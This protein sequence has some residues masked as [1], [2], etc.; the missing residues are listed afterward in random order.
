[1]QVEKIYFDMDG[2]LA[3]FDRGITELGKIAKV[4]QSEATLATDDVLWNAV[5]CVDNFYNKLE[6]IAGAVE[7]FKKIY[8][9]YGD[10]CEILSA[11]PKPHRNI[12][13]AREDKIKWVRRLLSDQVVINLVYR[14]EKQNFVKGKGCILID[15]YQINIDEWTAAGGTGILFESAD[16]VLDRLMELET[17]FMSNNRQV[18][19]YKRNFTGQRVEEAMTLGEIVEETGLYEMEYIVDQYN[20][21]MP[22]YDWMSFR[23]SFDFR[24]LRYFYEDKKEESK[25]G[26]IN[27]SY[28]L[29]FL[30][31]ALALEKTGGLN[32]SNRPTNYVQRVVDFGKFSFSWYDNTGVED[33]IK[34]ADMV[35]ALMAMIST[36]R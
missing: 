14:A 20:S 31:A 21:W 19:T 11:V 7:M 12:P 23:Y 5:R 13:S 15:D 4:N 24:N 32:S 30:R 10:K 25:R 18:E 17:V 29:R 8:S 2:V 1:M 28:A 3:D 22:S 6:P 27:E 33:S 35:E 26:K 36:L 16:E 34:I 9:L